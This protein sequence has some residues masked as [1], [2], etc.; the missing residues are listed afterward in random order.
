LLEVDISF[1]G[2]LRSTI[3]NLSTSS[4]LSG[5]RSLRSWPRH[6]WPRRTAAIPRIL[7]LPPGQPTKQHRGRSV[8]RGAYPCSIT[9]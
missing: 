8:P 3:E 9:D 1:V 2:T 4:Q 5:P 7:E 6:W